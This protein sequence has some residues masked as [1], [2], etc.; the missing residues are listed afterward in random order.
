MVNERAPTAPREQRT[1]EIFFA[2]VGP[3]VRRLYPFVRHVLAY[4]EAVGDLLPGELSADEAVDAVLIRAYQEFVSRP[5]R[6]ALKSWL[7]VLAREQLAREVA[8]LKSWHARTPVHTEEDVPATR[9][10]ELGSRLGEETLDFH[11]PD[12]DLKVEDLVPDLDLPSPEQH[13]ERDELHWWVEAALAGLPREWR[14][15]LLLRHV[16][17]LTGA[18]LARVA[19]T[20]PAEVERVLD[21]ARQYLR[22][23]LVESARRADT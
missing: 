8:R 1:R 11:E 21:L 3:H 9:P 17:G 15:I 19:G 16:E 22:Q 14:E 18:E 5:P 23:R 20:S 12:E 13:A 2:L 6:R 7:V 10:E 4:H